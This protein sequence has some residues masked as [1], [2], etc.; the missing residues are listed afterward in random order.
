MQKAIQSQL[1]FEF[2]YLSQTRDLKFKIQTRPKKVMSRGGSF[3]RIEIKMILLEEQQGGAYP[4][5]KFWL[6]P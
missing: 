4:V 1:D 6:C 3:R 5:K 2:D